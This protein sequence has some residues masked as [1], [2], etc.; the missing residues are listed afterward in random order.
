MFLLEVTQLD[1]QSY[2]SK[3][4]LFLF[5]LLRMTTSEE[6]E[7]LTEKVLG[8][9]AEDPGFIK[10]WTLMTAEKLE[11]NLQ[12]GIEQTIKIC[13]IRKRLEENGK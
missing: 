6:V 12:V 10:E 2:L 13:L 5:N 3:T 1:R 7:K 8:L 9:L 4:R 11:E